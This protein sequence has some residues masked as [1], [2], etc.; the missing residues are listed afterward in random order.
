MTAAIAIEGE[1]L[2]T[3][4][5]RVD[6]RGRLKP[7]FYVRVSALGRIIPVDDPVWDIEVRKALGLGSEPQ[8]NLIAVSQDGEPHLLRTI[9][10]AIE[11]GHQWKAEVILLPSGGRTEP[12]VI[13][14]PRRPIL[15]VAVDTGRY[16]TACHGTGLALDRA[17]VDDDAPPCSACGGS[18]DGLETRKFTYDEHTTPPPRR[19]LFGGGRRG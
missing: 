15:A 7:G 2:T 16:C 19:S 3:Y 8:R 11:Y 6:H 5:E 10:R 12:V 14:L 9:T 18:G 1:S 4:D 13:E 17:Q